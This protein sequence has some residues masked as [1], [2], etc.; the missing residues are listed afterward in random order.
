MLSTVS[1]A[2]GGEVIWNK[3]RLSQSFIS[4]IMDIKRKREK[5]EKGRGGREREG[6]KEKNN[7]KEAK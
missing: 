7:R 2:K 3:A 5:K 6:E 4:L 1:E